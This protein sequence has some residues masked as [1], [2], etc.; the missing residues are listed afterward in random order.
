MNV[1]FILL[2]N[3]LRS[4]D[5]RALK[6][7]AVHEAEVVLWCC[8]DRPS[9]PVDLDVRLEPLIS[10]DW[11]PKGEQ[12]AHLFDLLAYRIANNCGGLIL[13]LDTISIRPAWD[14]L[15]AD[16][17][18][19]TDWPPEDLGVRKDP[20]NNN[21]LARARSLGTAILRSEATWRMLDSDIEKKWGYLGPLMLTDLVK[22]NPGVITAAPYPALCGWAPG[23]I[24]RFFLGLE[25][26]SP[27]TRVIH[28]CRSAYLDLFEGRY[29]KWAHDNP[30]FATAVACRTNMNA[31][32]LGIGSEGND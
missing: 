3:E 7:A 2:G 29:E 22:H 27:E 24:W 26:P 23:Y 32:L 5:L 25:R 9:V 21:F 11:I 20:Y 17:V 16:V 10:P 13:G 4:G 1:N 8:G 31:D 30:E 6:S 12:P 28:L 19:S 14:L 15:T 18:L